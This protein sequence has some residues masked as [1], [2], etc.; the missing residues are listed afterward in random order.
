MGAALSGRGRRRRILAVAFPDLAIDLFARRAGG[1]H[2]PDEPFVL[3]DRVNNALRIAH[4]NVAARAGGLYAGQPFAEARAIIPTL[5]AAP[6][7]PQADAADFEK[8]VYGFFRYGPHVGTPAIACVCLDVAGSAHL[9]GGEAG[10]LAD[11]EARLA[12]ARL[13]A[14]AA[15]ADTPAAAF[16]IANCVS[17]VTGRAPRSAFASTGGRGGRNPGWRGELVGGCSAAPSK[18]VGFA[19]RISAPGGDADI[20]AGLPIEALG[21]D[22]D[23]AQTLRT[24]GLKTV[25]AVRRQ[26]VAALTKRFG[27]TLS[28][29]LAAAAGD[30]FE[31]VSPIAERPEYSVLQRSP[32]PVMT[33]DATLAA[34]RGLAEKLARMLERDGVGARR[35]ELRLFRLDNSFVIET[36]DFAA[37]ARDP[38][39][40]ARLFRLKFEKGD[41]PVDPGFGFDA[42]RLTANRLAPIA[43]EQRTSLK[44][45]VDDARRDGDIALTRLADRL[46]A[47]LGAD[48]VAFAESCNAHAPERAVRMTPALKGAGRAQDWPAAASP[49]GVPWRPLFLSPAPEPVEVMALAPDGPPARFIWRRIPYRVRRATGPE[50]MLGEWRLGQARVRDYYRVE[51]D[52]GRRFWIYREGEMGEAGAHWRLHGIFA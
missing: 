20:I 15:I 2:S 52:A 29:R 1:K 11:L 38:A 49:D 32:S 27:A 14:A 19:A 45:L 18:G 7:R 33:V 23:T 42:L 3:Y 25:D 46:G 22:P 31:S 36:I 43:P 37:P 4:A 39:A 34:T 6:H 44:S 51:D 48:A 24:L 50:R 28:R 21:L 30:L 41:R 9:F 5:R 47:V 13:A 8:I 17:P 10:L 26:P 16:A 35:F 12:R 40:I